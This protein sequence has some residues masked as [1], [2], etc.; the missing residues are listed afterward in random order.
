MKVI[1]SI[2]LT[3]A[4]ITGCATTENYEKILQTWVGK[5]VDELVLV[6]GPPQSSFELSTGDRVIEFHDVKYVYIP[7]LSYPISRTYHY[8][9]P[10][11]SVGTI[12]THTEHEIPAQSY[13]RSCKTRFI[14]GADE[15]IKQWEWEGDYCTALD[16]N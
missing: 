14:V 12:E 10:G 15:L 5:H 4:L 9:T 1:S 7:V 2:I 6:W 16:P 8:R 13:T 3:L 11:G